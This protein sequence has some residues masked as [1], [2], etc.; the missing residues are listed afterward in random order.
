M[1][2]HRCRISGGIFPKGRSIL[3]DSEGLIVEKKLIA[4]TVIARLTICQVSL[5]PHLVRA[6]LVALVFGIPLAPLFGAPVLII[7]GAVASP[8]ILRR[9]A[10]FRAVIADG[11]VIEIEGTRDAARWAAD[12]HARHLNLQQGYNGTPLPSSRL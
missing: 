11:S 3:L 6:G 5:R 7:M 4:W 8:F 10:L 1:I 9:R 12:W 2:I